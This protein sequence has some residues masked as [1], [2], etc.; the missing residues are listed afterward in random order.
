M[1]PWNG[2]VLPWATGSESVQSTDITWLDDVMNGE[3]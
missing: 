3:T 1:H 2:W